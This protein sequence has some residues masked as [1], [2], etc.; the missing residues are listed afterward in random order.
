MFI[1]IFTKGRM[2]KIFCLFRFAFHEHCSLNNC[3]SQIELM[4]EINLLSTIFALENEIAKLSQNTREILAKYL[5]NTCE[6]LAK[7]FSLAIYKF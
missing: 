5:Q 4:L 3:A 1:N 2:R 7:Y 6:I